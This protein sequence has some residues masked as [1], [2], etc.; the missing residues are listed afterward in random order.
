MK[1]LTIIKRGVVA[2]CLLFFVTVS[3]TA[4]NESCETF[5]QTTGNWQ[6][7]NIPTGSNINIITN[8][9]NTTM[10]PS[11]LS[12]D[13]ALDGDDTSGGTLVFN[14]T[15]YR[16]NLTERGGC[17]CY[18]FL[19]RDNQQGQTANPTLVL[20][21][22]DATTAPRTFTRRAVFTFNQSVDES[23]GWVHICA[24]IA[25]A[26]GMALPT[27]SEGVWSLPGGQTI[28]DWDALITNASGLLFGL[29]LN[30]DPT[31]RYAF[32]N[33][34]F[35]DC[36]DE[37]TLDGAF[38]CDESDNLVINGNFEFGD[39]GFSSDYTQN[40]ATYP[41]EYDVSNSAAA[42]GTAVTD[43]SF[44]ED[45]NLYS[46]ND[47]YLLVNGRTT[48]PSGTQS[49]VWEQTIS[50]IDPEKEYRLCANF[51]NLPQ[52]T[53]DILPEITIATSSGYT[54]TAVINTDASD[55]CDWQM[56]SF[57]FQAEEEVT[58]RIILNE[59][60][61]GDGNDLAI[62]DISVQELIDPNYFI[63]IQHQGN[64][65]SITGSLNT[66]ATGDDV[67]FNETCDFED[68]YYWFAY[69]TTDP[70]A[71]LFGSIVSGSF[72]YSSNINWGGPG[73]IGPWGLTTSFPDYNFQ[74]E[75]FYVIGMYVPS[76]CESC[77]AD[78]WDYQITYSSRIQNV[79]LELTEE[80][81]QDIIEHFKTGKDAGIDTTKKQA[82]NNILVY[83]NP[84]KDMVTISTKRNLLQQV[85][86]LTLN[87]QLVKSVT[88]ENG[89]R[90]MDIRVSDLAA[91]LYLV[92]TRDNQNNL[93]SKK[94]II[95]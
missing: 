72:G 57:C 84:A 79:P 82:T 46:T 16:G 60:G 7:S 56:E 18:D 59:D 19:V 76:C 23:D 66:I 88:A 24:P 25:L 67:L 14:Q 29:D 92:Q 86:I 12:G 33:I 91:G 10:G 89:K 78:S 44:C 68:K 5:D 77:Y 63:T 55:P 45:P 90:K 70:T 38:C 36:P 80:M 71:P 58:I 42:F 8:T 73:V 13:F 94:L 31:E 35:D 52:C 61:N 3:M 40:S 85:D 62:D 54:T 32:D 28:A 41:G 49:V 17:L 15:D 47:R 95:K 48:Q 74:S 30:S 87:G 75:R 27:S 51:K 26:Q 50:N 4:Q 1:N 34:C 69:E 53:F 22:G 37:G 6:R 65:N 83:P 64:A 39:T 43:H 2:M 93:Q 9:T 20:Y 11:G 81:K 21:Q